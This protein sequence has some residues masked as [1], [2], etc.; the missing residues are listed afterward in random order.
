MRPTLAALVWLAGVAYAGPSEQPLQVL[1]NVVWV[2]TPGNDGD[3]FAVRCGERALRVRLYFVDAPETTVVG[4]GMASRVAVQRRHFGLAR[5]EQ[6]TEFGHQASAFTRAALAQPFILYTALV[7]ARGEGRRVYGFVRTS[8]GEDLGTALVS[9]GLARAYGYSHT[10]PD[11]SPVA[12]QRARLARSEADARAAGSG[13][14][15]AA[16]SPPSIPASRQAR[17]PGPQPRP[18][19]ALPP[20]APVVLLLV[21]VVVLAVWAGMWT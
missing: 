16:P 20:A 19:Y 7:D 3:S 18:G 11:G 14:W 8:G 9:A 4:E 21:L 17:A 12:A 6:V 1:S 15:H 13:A 5:D 2:A 10:G